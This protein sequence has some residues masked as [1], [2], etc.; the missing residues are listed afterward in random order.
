MQ[1][2]DLNEDPYIKGLADSSMYRCGDQIEDAKHYLIHYTNYQEFQD[3]LADAPS[4][5]FKHYI[6]ILLYGDE[7]LGTETNRNIFEAVQGFIEF[8]KRFK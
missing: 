3:N 5:I 6:D 4:V 1:C 7:N 2:S 8:S